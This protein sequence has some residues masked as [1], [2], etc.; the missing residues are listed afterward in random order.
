MGSRADDIRA[1]LA[2]L[3]RQI[4]A[5]PIPKPLDPLPTINTKDKKQVSA[6]QDRLK[7]LGLYVKPTDG[8]WE[9]GTQQAVEKYNQ[10]VDARQKQIDKASDKYAPIFEE[11]SRLSGELSTAIS[12]DEQNSPYEQIRQTGINFVPAAT[13]YGLGL[14]KGV[15]QEGKQLLQ[16]EARRISARNLA[17]TY[18]NIDP[19]SPRASAQ[20]WAV[21]DEAKA[22]GFLR[23]GRGL[24]TYVPG[25]GLTALGL[26][27]RFLAAPEVR[28]ENEVGGES[29]LCGNA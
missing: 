22:S 28:K 5:L 10:M 12:K 9:S 24:K 21:G 4:N 26:S 20:I 11:R 3:D 6:V 25:L 16:D 14:Y 7:A 27:T 17:D 23:T 15:K 18:A 2:E 1:R 29:R 13:G 19:N 8:I